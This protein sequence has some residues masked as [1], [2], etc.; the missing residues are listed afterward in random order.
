[1]MYSKYIQN[2]DSIPFSGLRFLTT[3]HKFCGISY[4]GASVD[5]N[6]KNLNLYRVISISWNLIYFGFTMYCIIYFF[7]DNIKSFDGIKSNSSKSSIISVLNMIGMAGF[8]V[9]SFLINILLMIRG[10]KFLEL[11]KTQSSEFIDSENERKIGFCFT[12]IHFTLFFTSKII[13]VVF[14]YIYSKEG[15]IPSKFFI[16]LILYFSVTINIS[17]IISLIAYQSKI[18]SKQIDS[19]NASFSSKSLPEIY[20]FICKINEF[21]KKFD[22]FIS[23]VIFIN[24]FNSSIICIAYLCLI[25]VEFNENLLLSIISL[26]E[27]SLLIIILCYSCDIIPKRINNF[28]DEIQELLSTSKNCSFSIDL[29]QIRMNFILEDIGFTALGLIKI[30]SKTIISVFAVILSY[31]VVIIQTSYQS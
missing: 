4:F 24:I 5:K 21:V 20:Q 27:N 14:E 1:M 10:N 29:I 2:I 19:F 18:I 28:L 17:S 22:S 7:V 12:F 3:F 23:A 31:S 8:Y 15:F 26:T 11:F 16:H 30:N 6:V 13:F 25:A 9:Q